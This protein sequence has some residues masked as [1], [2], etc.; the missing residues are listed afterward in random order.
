MRIAEQYTR[1]VNSSS[2]ADDER[3]HNLD[4]LAAVAL[5]SDIGGALFRCK[6]AMDQSS[7]PEL[8]LVWRDKIAKKAKERGWAKHARVV[9]DESLLYWLDDRCKVCEGRGAPK[10]IH[11]P[12]LEDCVCHACDGTAKR[13]LV[14]VPTIKDYVLDALEQLSSMERESGARAMRK[15]SDQMRF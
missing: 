3:H 10:I 15:L 2:L 5:S 1:S 11:S 8:I 7:L 6:Y 13:R 14:V 4:A 12:I 9:A